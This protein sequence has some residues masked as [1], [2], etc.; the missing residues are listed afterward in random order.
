VAGTEL[1]LPLRRSPGRQRLEL[2]S[3]ARPPA[4][5]RRPSSLLASL[6]VAYVPYGAAASSSPVLRHLRLQGSGMPLSLGSVCCRSSGLPSSVSPSPPGAPTKVGRSKR[7]VKSVRASP[8]LPRDPGLRGSVWGTS[9][10]AEKARTTRSRACSSGCA[11]AGA[12]L[13][14]SAASAGRGAGGCSSHTAALI[15][16]GQLM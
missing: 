13:T 5:C 9:S 15:R 3:G 8:G 10:V 12:R 6:A 11:G 4:A 16:P 7:A 1:G 14:P 2:Q